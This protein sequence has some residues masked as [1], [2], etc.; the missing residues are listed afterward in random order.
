[1][2]HITKSW[3]DRYVAPLK[4]PDGFRANQ[5]H[6]RCD[7]HANTLTV[8]LISQF[9][10]IERVRVSATRRL[11]FSEQWA[12]IITNRHSKFRRTNDIGLKKLSVDAQS[13]AI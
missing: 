6:R 10:K 2:R 8:I 9:P 3:P 12:F 13:V 7:G 1:M 4:K 5:F 11:T